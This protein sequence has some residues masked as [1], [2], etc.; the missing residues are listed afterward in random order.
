MIILDTIITDL[1]TKDY[2]EIRIHIIT[3]MVMTKIIFPKKAFIN[4]QKLSMIFT[5]LIAIGNTK[6]P[7]HILIMTYMIQ[8]DL[9]KKRSYIDILKINMILMVIILMVTICMALILEDL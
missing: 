3:Q 5:D 1:I 6:I 7:D 4:I 8:M 2:I 9:I